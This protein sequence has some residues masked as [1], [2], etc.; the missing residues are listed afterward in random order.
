MIALRAPAR[1]GAQRHRAAA[2][3]R[4]ALRL[5]LNED[6]E[7]RPGATLALWRALE[8]DPRAACAGA[9]LLRP[10]G[11]AQA[12]AWRFPTPL[13]ALAGALFLHRLLAVQSRGSAHARGRLGPVGGAARAPRGRRAGRLAGPRVLRLLRRGRLPAAPARRRLAHPV[14]ARRGRRPPRAALDRRGA[15]A[16]DRRAG[17]QPR[18]VH[19]QAP[20]GRRGARGAL[21]DRVDL[22]ACARSPRS[23]CPGTPPRRYWRHVTRDAA[24]RARRGAAR[25]GGRATTAPRAAPR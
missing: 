16:A 13:T 8:G 20:L 6:S 3:G 18:P 24:P 23:C 17:A 9:R 21:A 11:A 5:L 7:L 15:R 2:R 19:A 4:G 12:S 1:Q 14:R 22:R 25:G 10:D